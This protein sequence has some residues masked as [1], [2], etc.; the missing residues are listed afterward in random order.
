MKKA[1]LIAVAVLCII[2][3]N[4]MPTYAQDGQETEGCVICKTPS[5]ALVFTPCLLKP[6]SSTKNVL[7]SQIEKQCDNQGGKTIILELLS[8]PCP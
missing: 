3:S 4:V 5:E 7:C 6:K 8:P 2:A 1:I